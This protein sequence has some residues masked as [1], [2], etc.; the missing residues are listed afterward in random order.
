MTEVKCGQNCI[1]AGPVSSRVRTH[2]SETSI[3]FKN[4]KFPHPRQ[5]QGA[6]TLEI[7]AGYS[8][9][10]CGNHKKFPQATVEQGAETRTFPQ[11][12]HRQGAD[13]SG[14]FLRL[15]TGRVRAKQEFPQVAHRQ[16]EDKS[17]QFARYSQEGCE[18]SKER[19][20]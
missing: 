15:H 11:A 14:H 17:G 12:T 16:G 1:S 5:R 2:S 4:P 7:S 9:A 8:G 10:G 18:P 3:V 13:K 6:D 20:K 19:R